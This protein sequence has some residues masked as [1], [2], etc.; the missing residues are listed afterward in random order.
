MRILCLH[1]YGTNTGVLEN[2]LSALLSNADDVDCRF[3]EGEIESPKA[4]SMYRL[5]D[6]V[7]V[8]LT[9]CEGLGAFATGPFWCYYDN[10]APSSVKRA[11]QLINEIIEDEGPFDGILGFSQGGSLAVAYLLQHE[12]DHPDEPCPFKF[13]MIF[14]SIISFTP[15]ESYC[16]QLVNELTEGEIEKLSAFPDVDFTSLPEGARTLFGTMARALNAG[17]EGGFLHEHP[18]EQVFRRRD[19]ALIPRILHP[20]LIESRIQIPTVHIVGKMDNPL[21]LEQSRLMYQLCDPK[22]SKWM[23]H[24]A[25]HDVPRM[26]ADAKAAYRA[27]LWAAEEGEQQ[28]VLCR[29]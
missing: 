25:G 16:M 10:F 1:G 7:S 9:L 22:V 23:E 20:S 29:L 2:Q 21:M 17:I 8:L 5:L 27:M 3:V 11:H 12:I 6:R 18:D 13:A 19:S 24:S 26:A 15:D 28:S 4:L 14:S